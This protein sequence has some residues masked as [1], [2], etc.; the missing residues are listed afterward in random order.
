ML[1]KVTGA[2]NE[3]RCHVVHAADGNAIEEHI[4]AGHEG[5]RWER[6]KEGGGKATEGGC[7][8]S[9]GG[10]VEGSGGWGWGPSFQ[11]MSCCLSK[12]FPVKAIHRLLYPASLVPTP[13][14]SMPRACLPAPR[15]SRAHVTQLPSTS[16]NPPSPTSLVHPS[17]QQRWRAKQA[18]PNV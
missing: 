18:T 7:G 17:R 8:L 11:E 3:N 6:V 16:L 15:L 12:R 2:I 14:T 5:V 1:R 10:T 4:C 9:D 13:P